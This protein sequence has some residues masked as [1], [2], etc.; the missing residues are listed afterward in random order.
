M[1]FHDLRH[2]FA[3][4]LIEKGVDIIKVKDLLGHSSVKVTER[5]THS[6]RE[7]RKRAVELLCVESQT[8]GKKAPNLLHNRYTRKIEKDTLLI[9][10]MFSVN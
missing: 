1:P 10:S 3:S 8:R 5:Y 7:E 6:S 9:S 2:T 4:R